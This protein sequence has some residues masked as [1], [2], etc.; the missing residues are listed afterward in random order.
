MG[1]FPRVERYLA[2]LPR[3]IQS[4]PE[5]L[6]RASVFQVFT[7]RSL[8][9]FP[10]DQAP[11]EIVGLLRT[12]VS[13]T[14]WLPTVHVLAANLAMLD[15]HRLSDAESLAWFHDANVT[16][17]HNRVYRALLAF[18][19]PALF[20]ASAPRGWAAFYRGSGIGVVQEGKLA[21]I[22]LRFP[23]Y[24]YCDLVRA[25][26]GDAFK[27]AVSLSRAKNT[28]VEIVGSTAQSCQYRLQWT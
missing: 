6:I 25:G 12:P 8:R 21:H 26:L 22:T 19:S 23:P 27:V 2:R 16:L 9:H 14:A 15:H 18:A 1:V 7:A 11:P 24:L 4:H 3:G 17:L 28:E 5:C 13:P 10:W 20:F